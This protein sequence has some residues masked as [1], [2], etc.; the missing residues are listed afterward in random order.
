[1]TIKD[2]TG[3][4]HFASC[5]GSDG[6]NLLLI[7]SSALTKIQLQFSGS[8]FSDLVENIKILNLMYRVYNFFRASSLAFQA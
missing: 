1:M 7:K 4:L 3:K 2:E 5:V 6:F 8:T